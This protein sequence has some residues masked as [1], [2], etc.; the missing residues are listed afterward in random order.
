MLLCTRPSET[1][2]FFVMQQEKIRFY[3]VEQGLHKDRLVH[4][5]GN[6]SNALYFADSVSR[7]V[8]GPHGFLVMY[9]SFVNGTFHENSDIDLLI[10][11]PS[12]FS[13]VPQRQQITDPSVVPEE[14]CGHLSYALVDPHGNMRKYLKADN[15]HQLIALGNMIPEFT[16]IFGRKIDIRI[17][18]SL[19]YWLQFAKRPYWVLARKEK[20]YVENL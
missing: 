6:I 12:L 13:F 20:T 14:L 1:E 7:F 15:N 18:E 11:D 17:Y 16:E 9:G 10:A 4:A 3:H 5:F 19:E 2:G 8:L